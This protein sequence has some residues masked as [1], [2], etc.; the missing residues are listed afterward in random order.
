M[1]F[2][3]FGNLVAGRCQT[4][5]IGGVGNATA[6]KVGI[7]NGFLLLEHHRLDVQVI[8]LGVVGQIFLGGGAGLHAHGLAFELL[9]A[10]HLGL[11]RHHETLAII[12]GHGSGIQA[13]GG[14][15]G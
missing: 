6:S 15:A 7:F 4:G 5:G 10:F 8:G 11:D 12:V 9:S 13:Q 14:I 3:V 1:F 2:G